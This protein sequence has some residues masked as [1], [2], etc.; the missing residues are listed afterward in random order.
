[1]TNKKNKKI[2]KSKKKED[3]GKKQSFVEQLKI[4][5]KSLE[6]PKK[7][8]RS[9]LLPLIAIGILVFLLP[10][11]LDFAVPISLDFN[12]ITFIV[13]GTIPIFLG[14]F[15][16]F[17][18]WKNKESD[19][20]GK[21]H[22]FITH[23]RVLAVSDLSLRD[24]VNMLGDKPA[25]GSLGQ[26]LKRIGVLSTQWRVPLAKS[27]RF[28]SDRTPSKI[29]RDF[30]DRF[31]QSLD[32]GVEPR[33]FIETEQ[34]AVLQEYKTMYEASN[35]NIVILS[36]VYVSMLIA[37]IFVMSFGIV[38]PIIMGTDDMN[39]FIYLSSFML[40]L[41]EGALLYL[42]K[43]MI[44]ADEV[45]HLTGE[46]GELEEN[47]D[48]TFKVSVM[49]SILLGSVLLFAK[50][51]ASIPLAKMIPFEIMIALSITPL[52]ITGIKI[53]IAEGNISRM[54]RNFLG[55]LPALGSISAMRGGK[56]NESV[57]YLSQKD[58]GVLTKHVRH[59][60]R[61]L[62]TR[63][64]DDDAWEWFGVDTGSNYI[65]RSSEMFREATY[66]AA[67]PH[68]VS[69]MI[70]E[71]IRKIRDLRIKKLTIVN[72]TTALFAGITF[73]ISFAIYISL[74]I[75]RHLNNIMIETGDPFAESEINIGAI[76]STVPT[77]IYT[78]TFMIVF[79]VLVAHSF[80]MAI[81]L[82]VLKGSHNLITL[83]YFVPFVWI[84]A[85]TCVT[86]DVGLSG[87]LGV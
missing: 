70:S 76:I 44:P 87:Y 66:A 45:W 43:S 8:Y 41:S 32:S 34:E 64:N 25:Y 27:F 15:Y 79:V 19:I 54:E 30:L 42:L 40:I 24:I 85:I 50:Y 78:Y 46:K 59:L 13:G 84:V 83:L 16:P 23:L 12:P 80:M 75:S 35:E 33:E 60:Y 10:F 4:S 11:I 2:K 65:Q 7:F 51:W 48:K 26:E 37:I 67:N 3:K 53:F 22:F 55:F 68:K 5:Y 58:Y 73:G 1:M 36:E 38:L 74:I 69:R 39:M 49:A 52:F 9:I 57:Y 86:V 17:I 21:M 14:L 56:I 29:L 63:I 61:R 72:T 28:V 47:I 20:N 6:D 82:R 81:T 71:N 77:E 31:S 18:S 62:R